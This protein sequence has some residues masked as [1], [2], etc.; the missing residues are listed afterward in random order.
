MLVETV[1]HPDH[2]DLETMCA[3]KLLKRGTLNYLPSKL[4][5]SQGSVFY[6]D[7]RIK[8]FTLNYFPKN[9]NVY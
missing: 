9:K 3:G 4:C 6:K 8:M 2:I 7:N 5:C 1:L